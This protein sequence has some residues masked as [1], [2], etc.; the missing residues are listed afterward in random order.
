MG[1]FIILFIKLRAIMI[2]ILIVGR[3]RGLADLLTSRATEAIEA[4]RGSWTT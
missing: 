2:L 1:V 3:Y 4:T